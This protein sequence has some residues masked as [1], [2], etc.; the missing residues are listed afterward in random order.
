MG[1]GRPMKF[2]DLFGRAIVR[3]DTGEHLGRVVDALI[4]VQA[5]T[6]AY[7]LVAPEAHGAP[8]VLNRDRISLRDGAPQADVS[9][10]MFQATDRAEAADRAPAGPLDLTAMPPLVIGPF[11]NTL[12]PVMGAAVFN[13]LAGRARQDRPALDAVH[14]HWHWFETLH[15]LPVFDGS[16]ELGALDDII[17][18][19][20]TLS[21]KSLELRDG[22]GKLFGFPFA[23]IRKVSRGSASIVLELS[24][25]PPYS[26]ARIQQE[27]R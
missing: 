6:L 18:D 23:T 5:G 17:F 22:S 10:A 11:G 19:P 2:N 1:H 20:A 26:I 4:D 12:A 9:G 25:N 14:A 13:A 7:L 24:A 3:S 15:G 21:C 8:F 16:G 27:L